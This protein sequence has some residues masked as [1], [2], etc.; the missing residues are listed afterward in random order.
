MNYRHVIYLKIIL[1]KIVT[2]VMFSTNQIGLKWQ[3]NQFAIWIPFGNVCVGKSNFIQKKIYFC[4][5]LHCWLVI[6]FYKSCNI[7]NQYLILDKKKDEWNLTFG[8][9]QVKQIGVDDFAGPQN[10]G[11]SSN[12]ISPA[13]TALVATRILEN[14]K[15]IETGITLL[16]LDV[17][18][19]LG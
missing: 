16:I 7:R 15:V 10:K 18:Q 12:K 17:H 2:I 14:I 4:L 5:K 13:W 8:P 6:L 9:R 1:R 3:K 11:F 19:V